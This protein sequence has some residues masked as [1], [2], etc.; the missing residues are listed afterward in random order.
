MLA[1]FLTQ[2]LDLPYLFKCRTTKKKS[3]FAF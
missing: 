1:Y 2:T 3:L